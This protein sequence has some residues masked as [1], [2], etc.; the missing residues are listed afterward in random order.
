M[1]YRERHKLLVWALGQVMEEK[2]ED[3]YLGEPL[4]ELLLRA[5]LTFNDTVDIAGDM[6][7]R[8]IA[9]AIKRFVPGTTYMGMTKIELIRFFQGL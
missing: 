1:D 7:P 9:E 4:D 6:D 5:K 3:N 8:S 2:D